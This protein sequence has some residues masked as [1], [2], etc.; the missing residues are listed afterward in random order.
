[1]SYLKSFRI[2]MCAVIFLLT[3]VDYNELYFDA[4]AT[5]EI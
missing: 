2:F 1:M 4:S 5:P 3:G